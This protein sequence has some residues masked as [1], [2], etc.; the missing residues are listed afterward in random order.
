MFYPLIK[1]ARP[2]MVKSYENKSQLETTF[3]ISSAN[4]GIHT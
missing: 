2:S 1:F 3:A 4:T